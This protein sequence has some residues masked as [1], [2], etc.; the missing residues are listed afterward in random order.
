M[1][2]GEIAVLTAQSVDVFDGEGNPLEKER[3]RIDWD[4]ASAVIASIREKTD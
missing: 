1:N 2:D 3:S 4:A